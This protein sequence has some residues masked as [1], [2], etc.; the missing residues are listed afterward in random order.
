MTNFSLHMKRAWRDEWVLLTDVEDEDTDHL[1]GVV[2]DHDQQRKDLMSRLP[3][4][5]DFAIL[6][7]GKRRGGVFRIE[8]E[9]LDPA[10]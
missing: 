4:V 1:E 10:A 2:V 7:T 9:D 3:P 5:I 8:V 6:F